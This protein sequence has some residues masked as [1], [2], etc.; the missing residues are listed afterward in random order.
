MESFMNR[1]YKDPRLM[2]SVIVGVLVGTF[3]LSQGN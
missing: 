3:A 1:G 2:F